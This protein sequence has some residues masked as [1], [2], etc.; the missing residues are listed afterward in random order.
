[1]VRRRDHYTCQREGCGRVCGRKG[2]A[3]VD[4]REPH[5]GNEALFFDPTNLWLLCKA[6]HDG[7]KQRQERGA[8]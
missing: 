6:C 2:E 8:R 5:R 3:V 7:W 4:H 1:M